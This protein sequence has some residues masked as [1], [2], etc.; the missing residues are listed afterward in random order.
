MDNER[1]FFNLKQ[2]RIFAG[3]HTEVKEFVGKPAE[4]WFENFFLAQ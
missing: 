4:V 2:K 3:C 1:G